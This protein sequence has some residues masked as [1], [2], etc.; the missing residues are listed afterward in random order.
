MTWLRKPK[1]SLVSLLALLAMAAT[2]VATA[3]SLAA[4]LNLNSQS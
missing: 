1:T 4:S 3:K 2:G